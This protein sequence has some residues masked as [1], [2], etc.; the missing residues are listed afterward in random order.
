MV[1]MHE[2]DSIPVVPKRLQGCD[3]PYRIPSWRNS[4]KLLVKYFLCLMDGHFLDSRTG[5][6]QMRWSLQRCIVLV[7]SIRK[8]L[9][10]FADHRSKTL[11]ESSL[12]CSIHER[13]AWLSRSDIYDSRKQARKSAELPRHGIQKNVR[14]STIIKFL[15]EVHLPLLHKVEI[16]FSSE[17]DET[18]KTA[19]LNSRVCSRSQR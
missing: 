1:R 3:I 14:M 2:K 16:S 18:L 5:E 9:F 15:I 11:P 6:T 17:Q 19:G 8:Y 13:I 12:L 10:R 4:I 7:Y